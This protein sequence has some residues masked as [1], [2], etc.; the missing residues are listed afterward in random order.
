MFLSLEEIDLSSENQRNKRYLIRYVALF[1][2]LKSLNLEGWGTISD[3]DIEYLS[4]KCQ[5]LLS[6]NLSGCWQLT[7]ASLMSLG[8]YCFNLRSI[9]LK[10]CPK[11]TND[12]L[13]VLSKNCTYLEVVNL[14]KCTQITSEGLSHLSENCPLIEELDLSFFKL[15]RIQA[16]LEKFTQL[17]ALYMEGRQMRTSDDV[18]NDDINGHLEDLFQHLTNLQ[19]LSLEGSS[20]VSIK[21]RENIAKYCT[22]LTVL[23]LKNT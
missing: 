9:N 10:S 1:P 11:I 15:G 22:K 20:K 16:G 12:G 3:V 17:K 21:A 19:K 4:E 8:E 7:D 14:S 18:D 6:L 5:A 13:A 2:F 23:N